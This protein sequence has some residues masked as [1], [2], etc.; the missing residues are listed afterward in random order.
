MSTPALQAIFPVEI[1]MRKEGVRGSRPHC[2]EWA[3]ELGIETPRLPMSRRKSVEAL[4]TPIE[5]GGSSGR[6]N[7]T[8]FGAAGCPLK[9]P[10]APAKLQY[11]GLPNCFLTFYETF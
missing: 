10:M 4:S 7:G 1:P 5:D 9:D 11:K 2:C 8:V 3:A 6:F